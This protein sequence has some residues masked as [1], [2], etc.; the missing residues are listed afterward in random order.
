MTVFEILTENKEAFLKGGEI[1]VLLF[2][3]SLGIGTALGILLSTIANYFGD[4]V[5]R[6]V[7]FVALCFTA[8]PPI[9][10]LYWV[11]YPMQKQLSVDLSPFHSAV[12]TLGA[13]NTLAVYRIV[14][15]AE[16][17]FPR[18]YLDAALV[19]GLSPIDSFKRIRLPI[20]T[21]MCFPRWLDQQVVILH[22]TIFA[23]LI[24][25]GELFRV[26]QKI[27]AD[28]YE[29][30]AIYTAMAILFL[31]TTGPVLVI[32]KRLRIRWFPNLSEK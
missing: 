15:D 2:L 11:H 3:S 23:S 8:I 26:A 9:V 24:S 12:I 25:V 17:D 10:L 31:V 6:L 13:L 27:N 7:D 22:S 30:I 19:C 1:T 29:T 18:H 5:T 14:S 16:R 20:L 4:T 28:N 32:S 21:R